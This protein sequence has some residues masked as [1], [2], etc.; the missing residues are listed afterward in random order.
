M[1]NVWDNMRHG[2][3]VLQ[4]HDE[5]VVSVPKQ[6]AKKEMERMRDAMEDVKFKLPMLSDGEIGARS[7]AGMK[8]LEDRRG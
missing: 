3:I 8:K 6:H 7:W 2:R 5:L 4:V 1:I